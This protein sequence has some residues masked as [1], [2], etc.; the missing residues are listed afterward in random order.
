MIHAIAIGLL[1]LRLLTF[2]KV[3][4]EKTATFIL[5]LVQVSI[6]PACLEEADATVLIPSRIFDFRYF[7]VVFTAVIFLFAE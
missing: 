4:N 5:A 1:W 7:L 3:V 6:I 2:L